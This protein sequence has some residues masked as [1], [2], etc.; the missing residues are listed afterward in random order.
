MSVCKKLNFFFY[1]CKE[2][3]VFGFIIFEYIFG[4]KRRKFFYLGLL[5]VF[6]FL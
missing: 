3:N 6:S 1:L 4:K 5:S 2:Y